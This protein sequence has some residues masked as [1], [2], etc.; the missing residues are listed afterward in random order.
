MFGLTNA[1][2]W[3][4]RITDD[5]IERNNCKG[6]F[7]YLNNITVCGKTKEEHDANLQQF[8]EAAAKHNLTFN[9]KKCTYLSDCIS[10]L[11]YQ[12]HNRTLPP[13]PERVKI[14]LHIPVPK[15]K[16]ELS[17]AIGLFAY[18]AKCCL[19]SLKV[20]PLVESRTFPLN[21]N[22]VRCF[23]QL[24]SE[25]AD[26]TLASVDKNAPFTLETDASD[27]A[28][29][30]VLQ[31]NG[32]SVAFWSRTLNLNEKSYASVEKEAAA[33]FEAVR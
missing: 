14:L 19:A 22:A 10:L 4:Q 1:V 12:I 32:R 30:T 7:A 28:V 2:P 21:K 24:K 25:L 20:K 13:D 11:G 26:A 9:K 3:F 8:L 33:I 5:I 17:R 29:S 6:A 16:K 23:Y 31:Q 18:Y 15:L 27:V